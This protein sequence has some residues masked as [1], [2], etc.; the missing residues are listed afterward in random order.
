MILQIK[1][2]DKVTIEIKNQSKLDELQNYLE[3]TAKRKFRSKSK[4][5]QK[6]THLN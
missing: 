5:P 1:K 6:F 2:Y 3:K 4:K